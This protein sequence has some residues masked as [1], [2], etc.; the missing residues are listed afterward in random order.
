MAAILSASGLCID[1]EAACLKA[2]AD[3]QIAEGRLVI[4][5]FKDFAGRREDAYILQLR[6]P[7][8]LDG[9]DEMDRVKRTNRIHVY[10][11]GGKLG[12]T[13][14]RLVGKTVR[15]KGSPFGQHTAHHHAPIVMQVDD[16]EPR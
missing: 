16:I 5:R 9:E 7:A 3:D 12:A 11:E 15:V 13:M 4:G 10:P 14:R 6:A 8:C 1:A 2:N